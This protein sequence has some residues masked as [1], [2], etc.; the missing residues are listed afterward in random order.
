MNMNDAELELLL[1]RAAKKGA[2]QAL[3][4]IGMGDEKAYDDIRELRSLLEVWRDTRKTVGHTVARIITTAVLA[5][6]A[7]GIYFE[8]G[9]KQ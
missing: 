2:Q 5:M 9:G 7:T 4:D 1:D 8:F 3:K 6:I